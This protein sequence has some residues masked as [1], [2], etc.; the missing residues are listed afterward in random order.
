MSL[1]TS[2]AEEINFTGGINAWNREASLG[3]DIDSTVYRI[4]HP[5]QSREL[6]EGFMED[7]VNMDFEDDGSLKTRG[8]FYPVQFTDPHGPNTAV[9]ESCL[10]LTKDPF[11]IGSGS[12]TYLMAVVNTT[13]ENWKFYVNAGLTPFAQHVW[14]A[15][16]DRASAVYYNDFWYVFDGESNKYLKISDAG[17][18]VESTIT[19]VAPVTS[20]KQVLVW[21]D[22]TW[23]IASVGPGKAIGYSKATDPTVWTAPDGGMFQLPTKALISDFV[24]YNDQ[25]YII[26][27]AN[28]IWLFTYGTDPGVD[29]FL[30]Q[31]AS[32]SDIPVRPVNFSIFWANRF[33]KS[34]GK[35]FVAG[36]Q[37]IYMLINEVLY[38][39]ADQLHLELNAHDGIH[40]HDI[41]KGLLV[42][43]NYD[44]VSNNAQYY[45]YHHNVRAWT[46]YEWNPG[47]VD[48]DIPKQWIHRSCLFNTTYG[49]TL[50]MSMTGTFATGSNVNAYLPPYKL[51]IDS[52]FFGGSSHDGYLTVFDGNGGDTP[53]YRSIKTRIKTGPLYMG[54][55]YQYKKFNEFLVDAWFGFRQDGDAPNQ[56]PLKATVEFVPALTGN[57]ELNTMKVLTLG[58][59]AEHPYRIPIYQRARAVRLTLE[60]EDTDTWT[61]YQSTS[62]SVDEVVAPSI[63]SRLFLVLSPKGST[64]PHL[65]DRNANV[66]TASV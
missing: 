66:D 54:L 61:D 3:T 13:T 18:V 48:A 60:V 2:K 16:G 38:P 30:R 27:V 51:D 37:N 12:N 44:G 24:V 62:Q 7:I 19:F 9:S 25:M 8:V 39:I 36:G 33:V 4:S 42:S 34:D 1:R 6:P 14:V 26:D 32:S 59:R 53:S 47:T 11:I 57:K 49:M 56:T 31:I 29:G 22:R 17:V 20:V 15:T 10:I 40:L 58:D 65:D 28:N 64:R 43:L 50:I 63:I 41:G 45:V 55:K 21:K 5:M 52:G 46:R 23:G 35:L